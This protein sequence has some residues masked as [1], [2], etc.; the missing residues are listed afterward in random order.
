[1]GHAGGALGGERGTDCAR[2]AGDDPVVISDIAGC[3]QSGEFDQ[4]RDLRWRDQMAAA[5]PADLAFHTTLLVCALF[6]GNAEERVE[7]VVGPQRD[8]PLGLLAVPAL[9]HSG[10]RGLEVVVADP[11]RHA[12][13]VLERRRVSFEECFLGLVA[14]GNVERL[15]ATGQAHHEHPH[16]HHDPV[17]HDLELTE[18]D[19]GLSAGRML[20]GDEHLLIHDPQLDPA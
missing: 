15:P 6:A 17:Q 20:L 2:A 1:M 10:H 19:L 18:V 13:E 12:T 8:E 3:D 7:P 9:Q 4:R 5:E 16:L 11:A 14:V